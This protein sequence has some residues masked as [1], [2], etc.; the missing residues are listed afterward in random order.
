MLELTRQVRKTTPDGRDRGSQGFIH[1][2]ELGRR[3]HLIGTR[4]GVITLCGAIVSAQMASKVRS[5]GERAQCGKG[6]PL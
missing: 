2:I 1:A 3:M 5:D 6:A 4:M